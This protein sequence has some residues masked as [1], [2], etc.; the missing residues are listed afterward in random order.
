MYG[1]F[2]VSYDPHMQTYVCSK[3]ASRAARVRHRP[4]EAVISL[5]ET[6]SERAKNE[7]STR[8][9]QARA[10]R[11]EDNSLPCENQPVI[12]VDLYGAALEV[13]GDRYLICPG[14]GQLHIYRDTGWGRDG[15]RCK[16]CRDAET[17][18]DKTQRCAYCGGTNELRAVDILATSE[19]PCN[20]RHSM[21]GDPTS[22]YQTPM[23]C[24]K[25]ANSI[26]LF[27]KHPNDRVHEFMPKHRLWA[28]ISPATVARTIK[29][30]ERHK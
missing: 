26:G 27:A 10:E 19:D 11:K 24:Q 1:T 12:P 28:L 22:C 13:D 2:G 4:A 17:Q 30:Y 23:F 5:M 21:V 7:T 15:Y 18:A 16:G 20:P 6:D 9:K 29:H 8:Q 3:K 25:C 14:C